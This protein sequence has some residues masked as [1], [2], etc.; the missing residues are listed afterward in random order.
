[1]RTEIDDIQKWLR[2]YNNPT[3]EQ[4]FKKAERELRKVHDKYGTVNI[5][6]IKQLIS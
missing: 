4:A 2:V 5:S 6:T 1:M 3:S